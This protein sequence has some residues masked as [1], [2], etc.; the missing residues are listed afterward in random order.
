MRAVPKFLSLK[1]HG[2]WLIIHLIF[3]GLVDNY[4]G[5]QTTFRNVQANREGRMERNFGKVPRRSSFTA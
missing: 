5:E 2:E 1:D 4:R 3:Y